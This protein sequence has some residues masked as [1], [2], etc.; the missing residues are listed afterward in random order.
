[1]KQQMENNEKVK[2]QFEY[3][4]QRELEE[5][6]ANNTKAAFKNIV[7]ATYEEDKKLKIWRE[8]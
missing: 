3:Q 2:N 4:R 6:K 5:F 8:S 1:M 7:M